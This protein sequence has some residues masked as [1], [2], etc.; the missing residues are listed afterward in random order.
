MSETVSAKKR[1]PLRPDAGFKIP[2]DPGAKPYLVASKCKSCGKFFYP[3]RAI[4]LNCGSQEMVETPLAGKG[5][6]YTYT[7]VHHQVPG[8]LLK[9][10]Y[11]LAIIAMDEGCSVRT[12]ITE[13][14]E[15]VKVGQRVEAYFEKIKE[16][17]QGNEL[18]VCKFRAVK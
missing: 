13:K 5:S 12:V 2:D 10:P 17:S 9:V 6:V 1:I 11:V 8:A 3:T 7:T 4:C 15:S 18:I 14:W 16:D